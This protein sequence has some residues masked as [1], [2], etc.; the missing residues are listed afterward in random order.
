M[1]SILIADDEAG[2]R[3]F[4]RT[5]LEGVGHKVSEAGNGKEAAALIRKTTFDLVIIDLIMPEGEGLETI[6]SLTKE[7]PGLRIIAVS[8]SFRGDYLVTMLRIAKMLGAKA[9][10]SKPFSAD[11]VLETVQRL[12]D[13]A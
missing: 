4:L 10:L 5:V 7:Y 13:S 6:R 12:L 2:V 1:P 9:T 11:T 3:R 8:G